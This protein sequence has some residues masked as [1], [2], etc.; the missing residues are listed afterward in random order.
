MLLFFTGSEPFLRF[1]G[2]F[3]LEFAFA[4]KFPYETLVQMGVLF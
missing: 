4:G 1:F 3:F 2:L